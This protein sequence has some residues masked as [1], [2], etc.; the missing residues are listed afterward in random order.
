V[1]G[2]FTATRTSTFTDAHL[3]AVMPEVGADFYALACA[4]IINLATAQRWTEEL[5]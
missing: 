2:T 5:T 1:N 3:R 4:Q